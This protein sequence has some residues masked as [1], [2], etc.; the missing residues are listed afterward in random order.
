MVLPWRWLLAALAA[1]ALS[2]FAPGSLLSQTPASGRL[3]SIEALAPAA[4]G[5]ACTAVACNRGSTTAS[6]VVPT[7]AVVGVL[8]VAGVVLPLRRLWRRIRNATFALPT[9]SPFALLRPP[10]PTL[11]A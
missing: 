1:L 7:V 11:P 6:G 10:Q 8:A 4:G 9:G 2:L 5:S 3:A